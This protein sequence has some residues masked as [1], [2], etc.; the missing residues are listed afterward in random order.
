MSKTA[1][2][3]DSNSGISVDEAGRL[4]AFLVPM[5]FFIDGELYYEGRTLTQAGFY[6]RMADGAEKDAVMRQAGSSDQKADE[7]TA[8]AA[9]ERKNEKENDAIVQENLKKMDEMQKEREQSISDKEIDSI[10]KQRYGNNYRTEQS[11]N[12]NGWNFK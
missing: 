1:I 2:V 10:M 7:F 12:I 5:P 8:Q 6:R 9:E 4:G 11:A 3:T